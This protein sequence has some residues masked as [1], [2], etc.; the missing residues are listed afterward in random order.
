[1]IDKAAL[2]ADL[3]GQVRALEADLRQ[4]AEQE[5]EFAD[6]L[7]REWE[8]AFHV[9]RTAATYETWLDGE[10]AQAAMAWVLGTV[11][12][13]FCEDNGLIELPYLAGPG[14]RQTVA[15]ERHQEFFERY[16]HLT[17]R[18]WIIAGLADMG[19]ASPVA[20]GLFGRA[21]NP[22]WRIT[23]SHQAAKDLLAFWR[24]PGSDGSAVHNFTDPGWDTRFLG[25]LY[26]DLSEH[27]KKTYALLQTPEFVEEFILDLTLDPAIVEFGL[28]ADPPR[29]RPDLPRTLRVVDPACGSG[30]FLLGAFWRL[31]DAWAEKHQGMDRWD[32]I[33]K[34]LS[35]LHGV[36]KNPFAVSIARFRLLLA[37]MKAGETK[38][39]AD[40]KDFPLNIAVGDSLLHGRGGAGEQGEL[41]GERGVF[42]YRSEDVA[43]YIKDVDLL[44]AG[45]YHVVVG[46]PPYITVKDRKEN[47]NY[48]AAYSGV[49]AGNYGLSVP[50]AARFFKLAIA[51]AADR[52]GSG[53]VGQITAN[54]FMKREFG[55]K[56]IEDFFTRKEL[57]Y[58]IDTSGASI[59]GHGTPTVIL[60]GRNALATTRPVRAVL[61]VRG[62]PAQPEEPAKGKVWRAIVEQI[63]QPGSDS[64]WVTVTDL[65]RDRLAMHPWSLAG[66][67]APELLLAIRHSAQTTIASAVTR[68]GFFGD[69]H[70]DEIF[71]QPMRGRFLGQQSELCAVVS[72]RG[73]QVRDW[74]TTG[75]DLTIYPYD[76]HKNVF[77]ASHL[78]YSLSRLLWP[79][80]TE[81]GNRATFT[82]GT[83]FSDGRAWYAWHQLPK[84]RDTHPWTIT[85]AFVATHNHFVLDRDGRVFNRTAPI[86]KLPQTACEDDYLKLLGVLNS[87]TACFW[88]QQVSHN[89]GEGGGARV[90]AGYSAMGSE[91]WKNCFEFTGT[92]L[93]EFP[94]PSKLPLTFG[95]ELDG[96]AQELAAVEPA[97]R[98]VA[99]PPTSERLAK[100]F[101]EH[102]RIRGRMIAVQEEMD[103]EVYWLYGLLSKREAAELRADPHDVPELRLGERSF[104]IVLARQDAIGTAETQWFTR[105]GSTPITE[106]PA[107]WPQAYQDVVRRRIEM[108]GRRRD[109]ALIERPE[110][111]RRWQAEPWEKKQA[112]ALRAWL[113][114]RCERRDLWCAPSDTG[115]EEPRPMTVSRLADRLRG[116]P[117]FVSVARL[118]AGPDADLADVIT[119]ITD[120]EHVPYLAALRYK[121]TGLRKR[122]QW[123]RTWDAQREEDA[124]GQRLNIPVPPKYTSADFRKTSYWSNR[125]KLDVPK[126]R[127]ISY[128]L[129]SPDGDGSL[130]L[131]WAGW[132]HRQLAH[133]LMTIAEDR[134]GRDDWEPGRLVPLIAG[135][136]ELMPW[137]RQW[138]GEVDPAFGMSPADA[139]ATY[140]EDQM[141]RCGVSGADLAAWRPPATGRGRRA[142]A[143]SPADDS[144]ATS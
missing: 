139:Y 103:W 120:A 69:T 105:H 99:E 27:A 46:N 42:T 6:P 65:A 127:F 138:H 129:A 101:A 131:G 75:S 83:Y 49:C 117:D 44:G 132:D 87:S 81:L 9:R 109:I 11:F 59:P 3:K 89:K 35:G 4:R 14:E 37:V 16:P 130:L 94:I 137:V 92:K 61:G 128:P 47:E 51:A 116:D 90:D 30:H 106:I 52:R 86:I 53:F 50:F 34:V 60:V 78:S 36:D 121:D 135:L 91:A 10:V 33:R 96:L 84:D 20:A 71:T 68:I 113:L 15:S 98:P 73:D 97:A 112:A 23:L 126:E 108:I 72:Q 41:F 110:C 26:Q 31:N 8:Q 144:S 58:V 104:E 21:H 62:E 24:T 18:D 107:Y 40:A 136:A 29:A 141:H 111:K 134:S 13:R 22:M 143:A 93:L 114:D 125:G 100:A 43:A 142:S 124:T 39:L 119:A 55:K 12:L 122:A 54:S 102:S 45:T 74:S 82:G 76:Q 77:S 32:R 70:A 67:G 19:H 123:E 38:C 56:L 57:T 85:F 5:A 140:L 2:L 88:L 48:R 79:A 25:D 28:D 80:R 66:G 1:M 7:L 115:T 63:E 118:Y 17:D 64:D 133:V 95:R